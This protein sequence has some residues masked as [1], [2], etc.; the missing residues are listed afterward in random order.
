VH[1]VAADF[2]GGFRAGLSRAAALAELAALGASP[3]QLSEAA[4]RHATA[5]NWYAITAVDLLLEAG[6]EQELIERHI[7]DDWLALDRVVVNGSA[8]ALTFDEHRRAS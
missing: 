7:S 8:P 3:D 5:D 2:A 1:Q 6:A 4:A